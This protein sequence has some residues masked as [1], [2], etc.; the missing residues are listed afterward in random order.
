MTAT[1]TDKPSK[2][3]QWGWFILLWLGGF[4]FVGAISLSVKMIFKIAG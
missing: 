3:K 4:C 1:A 2:W